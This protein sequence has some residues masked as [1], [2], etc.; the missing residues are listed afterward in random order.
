MPGTCPWGTTE[1]TVREYMKRS[2]FVVST[3]TDPWW[4]PGI[5]TFNKLFPFPSLHPILMQV[6][7]ETILPTSLLRQ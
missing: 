7:Q 4:V 5:K 2:R 3:L 6:D 1:K